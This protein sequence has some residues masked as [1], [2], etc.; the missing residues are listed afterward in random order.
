MD[1]EFS[2]I[3]WRHL[4]ELTLKG[5]EENKIFDIPG[6]LFYRPGK[7]NPLRTRMFDQPLEN[8][9]GI[10][11]GP[12]SQMAQNI[13][14]AWL[15]GARYI[16]LKT[17]Q[18]DDELDIPRP[19]IDMP[20]EGYNCEFSQELKIQQ[21]YDEYL[22]AWILI[23]ILKDKFQWT[24]DIGTIFNMSLGYDLEGIK[25]D[26]VQW[27]LRKMND[28]SKEKAEKIEAITDLYPRVK[29]LH[30]PDCIS[31]NVT[32]S[33][34]HGCPPNEIQQIGE[35]LMKDKG[36]HTF[37][38]FNPTLLGPDK[39]R[40]ILREYGYLT[41][42]PDEAFEHDISYDEAVKVIASLMKTAAGENLNFGLKLTNT[43]E[44]INHKNVFE[45]DSMFM[46]GK[47]LH[48]ISVNVARKLKNEEELKKVP[49]SFSGGVDVLNIVDTIACGLN[50]ITVSTDLLRP[51]GYGKLSQYIDVLQN[52]CNR[53]DAD[54]LEELSQIKANEKDSFNAFR[55]NLNSY[56]DSVLEN[57]DY[58][59]QT[60]S[61]HL[62]RPL[63]YFDCIQAPCEGT[64]P[65]GQNV[66]GYLYYAARGQYDKAFDVIMHDNPFPSVSGM[67]CDH[68]CQ[69]KCTR[70]LYEDSILI[71][72]IKSFI[73]DNGSPSNSIKIPKNQHGKVAIIGAGPSGLS[74]AYYLALSGF[75]VDI[76][77]SGERPGGM[78]AETIP[79]F[80]L[81]EKSIAQDIQRIEKM[82]VNIHYNTR[83]DRD[84]FRNLKDDFDFIY[85]AVG[86]QKSKELK[87][88]GVEKISEGLVSPLELLSDI[89]YSRKTSLGQNIIVLGGGNVAVDVARAAKRLVGEEGT[90]NLVYRRTKAEMPADEEE[91]KEALEE[92]IGWTELANPM[93]IQEQKGQVNAVTFQKMKI[94]GKD[95][96][97]RSRPVPDNNKQFVMKCDT[98]IPAFGQEIEPEF[99]DFVEQQDD[100]KDSSDNIFVGGDAKRGASTLIKAIADGKFTAWAIMERKGV[101]PQKRERLK[102]D[103]DLSL[104][105][106]QYKKARVERGIGIHKRSP[107]ERKDFGLVNKSLSEKEAQ[108]EAGRCMAC[109]EMC[110]ICVDV[111]PNRANHSYEVAP[112]SVEIPYAQKENGK[113][114]TG[115]SESFTLE[116]R[117]QILNI[118]DFCNEC[119][120]C[121]TFCPSSGAPYKDKP[122]LHLT[123]SGFSE[124]EEGFFFDNGKLYMK[125][126]GI[127]QT[128]ERK[129]NRF[130]FNSE[131]AQAEFWAEDFRLE[132]VTLNTEDEV[133]FDDAIRMS[134]IF[135]AAKALSSSVK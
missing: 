25:K 108:Q 95:Q 77:E 39:I 118:K 113:V 99:R 104:P 119:G 51:G 109:D 53:T 20:F 125:S 58:E 49:V 88:T 70:V 124:T 121:E 66:P 128:L 110:N 13:V 33:T 133:R 68:E 35:Y 96:S 134:V 72:E 43:L 22:N 83:V 75:I 48:P 56:A 87:T 117:Y 101:N 6:V 2:M 116:Q 103:K 126:D 59:A 79:S 76:F 132:K 19:C 16:E 130:F 54:N 32:L 15:C 90:V 5:V 78:V 115:T 86:A 21:S 60:P 93:E 91:L 52:E 36:L 8:P 71:R 129:A 11:A 7:T 23:H 81:S 45:G 29:E 26:N 65:S 3:T 127:I 107:E 55:K 122:R 114:I 89:K 50:P 123:E 131:K 92:G 106:L 98:L 97:G 4:L 105:E 94:E 82:G 31:D 28:C 67:I 9:V 38:K 1:S 100:T 111:C 34:M 27:F 63:N 135:E 18:T 112:F 12:H 57:S 24:E 69:T 47:A 85:I 84:K 40:Y 64:C 74:C 62:E 42:V 14:A 17:V 30:I 44:S 120:N 61:I 102:V 41:K 37:I 80:R 46:S 10:S 73:A